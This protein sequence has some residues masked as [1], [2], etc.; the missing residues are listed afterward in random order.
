[1]LDRLKDSV[2]VL[3]SQAIPLIGVPSLRPGCRDRE[4]EVLVCPQ[5]LLPQP[6]LAKDLV[7]IDFT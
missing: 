1:M 7:E 4:D 6:I 3:A 5:E 2:G